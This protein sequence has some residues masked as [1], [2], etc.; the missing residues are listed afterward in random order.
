M[1]K[2]SVGRRIQDLRVRREMTQADLGKAISVSRNVI[3]KW[4][5]EER[6]IKAE[7]LIALAD[8]FDVSVDYI[9]GRTNV[10][11]PDVR[12][13]H[14]AK[15]TGLSGDSLFCIR[16]AAGSLTPAIDGVEEDHEPPRDAEEMLELLNIVIPAL[17]YSYLLREFY[18]L[19][20]I[21][22]ADMPFESN[23]GKGS[24]IDIDKK[25]ITVTMRSQEAADFLLYEIGREFQDILKSYLD[26]EFSNRRLRSMMNDAKKD[27]P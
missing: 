25:H 21:Y 16:D 5:N 17:P 3:A 11:N 20:Q 2:V 24:W 7:N 19:L 13:A 23:D 10:S 15:M 22:K 9:L 26:F 12:I 6:E 14:I 8:Y 27:N 4:E 18:N 1:K